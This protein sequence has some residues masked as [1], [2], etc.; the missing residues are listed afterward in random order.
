M[1]EARAKKIAA[2][3][4]QLISEKPW[5]LSG[6]V[7]AAKRPVDSLLEEFVEFQAATKVIFEENY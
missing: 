4:K 1:K 2:I 3:E 6:E 7:T 5:H